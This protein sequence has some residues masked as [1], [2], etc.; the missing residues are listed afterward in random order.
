MEELKDVI[1]KIES[2]LEKADEH[3]VVAAAGYDEGWY[4]GEGYAYE[5]VLALLKNISM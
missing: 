4:N 5:K 3:S 1:E 2:L